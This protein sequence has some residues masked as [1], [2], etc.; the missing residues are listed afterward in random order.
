MALATSRRALDKERP[1]EVHHPIA[2]GRG[3]VGRRRVFPRRPHRP[4]RPPWDGV[5]PHFGAL[6][7]AL[8]STSARD[9]RKTLVEK[10]SRSANAGREGGGGGEEPQPSGKPPDLKRE[11]KQ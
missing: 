2:K 5:G 1:L 6:N 9:P 8:E 4:P 3:F 10:N 11:E 7:F